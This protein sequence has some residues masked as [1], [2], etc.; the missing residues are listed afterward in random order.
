V[1]KA[2]LSFLMPFPLARSPYTLLARSFCMIVAEFNI[3]YN[4]VIGITVVLTRRHLKPSPEA[5]YKG[6]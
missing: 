5:Y 3:D 4:M 2:L 1:T 6:L